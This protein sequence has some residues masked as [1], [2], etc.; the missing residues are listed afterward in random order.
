[1]EAQQMR[2][3]IHKYVIQQSNVIETETTLAK[4]KATHT[5]TSYHRDI[6]QYNITKRTLRGTVLSVAGGGVK[7]K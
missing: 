1:M 4:T 7:T 2:W 3:V 6:S 5:A